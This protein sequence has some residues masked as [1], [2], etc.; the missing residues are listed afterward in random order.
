MN[1][2]LTDKSENTLASIII[3]AREGN[4]YS[5]KIEANS[6]PDCWLNLFKNF[7]EAVEDQAFIRVD[8]L[9]DRINNLMIFVKLGDASTKK[10]IRNLQIYDI[11]SRPQ[12][13]FECT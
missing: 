5:G 7:Q 13:T 1:A 3:K 8:H 11:D 6:F 4:L 10:R 9:E 2:T 12:F